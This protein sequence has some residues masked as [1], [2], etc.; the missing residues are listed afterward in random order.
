MASDKPE[1]QLDENGE[2]SK[3]HFDSEQDSEDELNPHKKQRLDYETLSNKIDDLKK[4][5]NQSEINDRPSGSGNVLDLGGFKTDIDEKKF[6][7]TACKE[8]LLVLKN[9]QRFNTQEWKEVRYA[10]SLKM[11]AAKPGFTDLRINEELCYVDKGKDHLISTERVMAGLT[12]AIL[13][14]RELLQNNLEG[15]M[16]Y[17]QDNDGTVDLDVMREIIQLNFGPNSAIFKNT[18][19]T[20][21]VICGK[22]AEC[23]EGRRDR[24]LSGIQNKNVQVAMR[25][26]APSEEYLFDKKDL[27]SLVQ[28][29]GGTQAWLN[30]PAYAS[31]KKP[32]QKREQGQNRY[33]RSFQV[34]QKPAQR[35]KN[36]NSRQPGNAFKFNNKKEFPKSA[37]PDSFRKRPEN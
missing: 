21:Q 35:F 20:L 30:T 13:D 23:I 24:L 15:M 19:Q 11:F 9:L 18:E 26:I 17:I 31:S 22:R 37:P 12:N 34:P 28:S 29:L 1:N 7:Q 25:N 10:N 33:Q 16:Q 36:A 32:F 2:K 5:L 8:R 14:Q 3:R 27:T 6:V 4:L